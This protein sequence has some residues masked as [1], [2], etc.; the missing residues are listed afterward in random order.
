MVLAVVLPAPAGEPL[1]D[2]LEPDA[3]LPQVVDDCYSN[4]EI[5]RDTKMLLTFF[6]GAVVCAVTQTDVL[7]A[8]IPRRRITE[9]DVTEDACEQPSFSA[10][11]Q[12][13]ASVSIFT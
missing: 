10:S 11:M 8:N 2:V 13:P 9:T 1:A 5:F 7:T 3:G 4:F 6:F 12:I